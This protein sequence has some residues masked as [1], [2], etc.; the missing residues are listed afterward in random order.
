M[1]LKR[2][3]FYRLTSQL[4]LKC[5]WSHRMGFHFERL[6]F[7]L[8]IA[9]HTPMEIFALKS[10]FLFHL[11][12]V[13]FFW[14]FMNSYYY[15][16]L[17]PA[18]KLSLQRIMYLYWFFHKKKICMLYNQYFWALRVCQYD[19]IQKVNQKYLTLKFIVCICKSLACW[20]FHSVWLVL[21]CH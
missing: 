10:R 14:S 16:I 19:S 13:P 15:Y 1:I 5:F 9:Q 18:V 3:F 4:R 21:R 12:C 6:H 2:I 8:S 11:G 7:S 17:L 20:R